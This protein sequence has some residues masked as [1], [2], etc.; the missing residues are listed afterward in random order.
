M[1]AFCRPPPSEER[2]RDP[3]GAWILRLIARP[4]PEVERLPLSNRE[5]EMQ[6]LTL[7]SGT[8]ARVDLT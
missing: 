6:P 7:A 8:S 4:H 3:I 1:I 5:T 2:Q